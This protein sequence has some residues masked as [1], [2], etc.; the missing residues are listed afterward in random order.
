M[1]PY[2]DENVTRRTPLLTVAIIAVNALVWVLVEGAGSALPLAR[3][4]CDL[5]LIPGELSGPNRSEFIRAMGR[6]PIVKMSRMI[7]PTPVAA[8]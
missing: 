3:A 4:V 2:H 1:I 7:P 6:A 5:G 8:P